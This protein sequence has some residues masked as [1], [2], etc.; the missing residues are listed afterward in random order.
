MKTIFPLLLAILCLAVSASATI[1]SDVAPAATGTPVRLAANEP[2]AGSYVLRT[3]A[4][5]VELYITS[6]CPW[7]KK[8]VEFFRARGI[9]FTE[10]DIEK[11][12]AAARRH[13]ELAGGRSGVPFAVINGQ[14]IHGYSPEEY[15]MALQKR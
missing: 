14:R 3:T 11:D 1:D 2:P 9:P 13:R 6:W 5:K 15:E 7:C 4:P 12:Q 8:A 10:Y